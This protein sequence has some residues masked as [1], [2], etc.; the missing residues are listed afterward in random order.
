MRAFI[1]RPFGVK[2]GIDF[3]RVERELIDPVLTQLKISGRTTGEILEAGNIRTDMF[4]QLLVAD[5]VIADISSNNANAFYELGIR[6][7]LRDRHTFLLR[8]RTKEPKP[9]PAF[10]DAGASG[11]PPVQKG[12]SDEVPFDL[13]TDRYLAYDPDNP[14]GTLDNLIAALQETLAGDRKDSPVFLSLP[15]LRSPDRSSFTPVP[16][17]FGEEVVR[18]VEANQ[19]ERL[20][21]LALEVYGFA[22][23]TE[24]LRT[25]GRAQFKAKYMQDAK[26]TWDAVR[27]LEPNDIEANL[28]LA[29][30]YAQ[31]NNIT[32]S[33]LCVE[34]VTASDGVRPADLAEAYALSARNH[35]NLW[36]REWGDPSVADRR[37]Q[38]FSSPLLLNTYRDYAR[39]FQQDLNAYYPGINALALLLV[40]AELAKVFP[41]AWKDRFADEPT[42]ALELEKMQCELEALKAAVDFCVRANKQ[43][44][45]D[46]DRWLNITQAD[47]LLLTSKRPG[48]VEYAYRAA[49]LNL[50]EMAKDSIRRQLHI[51]VSLDVLVENAK[52]ALKALGSVVPMANT[53]IKQPLGHVVLF[54]GHRVD[55][56]NRPKP[57]FPAECEPR[58][59]AEIKK[60]VERV[61][62][63]SEGP[64]LGIAGAASG[65]DILFH[66]VCRELQIST[67]I[68]LALPPD[69]YIAASVKPAG[70][71]WEERFHK[72]GAD[73]GEISVLAETA[74]LQGWL[75]TKKDYDIWQRNNLWELCQALVQDAAHVSL[76]A[77]WDGEK[78]D[79]PGGTEHMVRIAR[80][81]DARISILDIRQ[82][83]DS[84]VPSDH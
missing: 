62:G 57:R 44:L 11:T 54:T 41:D 26:S 84:A 25:I 70:G 14:S 76:I 21:L 68:C 65:G 72:L 67:K 35:K 13:R 69:K 56:P 31:L 80:E 18:A 17:D 7:A 6:H 81:R 16:Q 23:E 46:S 38:A 82:I 61:K 12:D 8:S 36:L 83:C 9:D 20:A 24:G 1:I 33:N 39:A 75:S 60:A 40:F 5:L 47:W 43:R 66:E 78:G 59:R 48:Q 55:A 73:A 74:D 77:L 4:Q 32:D 52:A 79:G 2:K 58:V 30:I 64:I 45:G 49:T 22:W 71:D 51:Y 34:R 3:D 19:R 37:L 27:R 15:G 42:A 10:K 50:D 63:I 53:D 29:T 28:L